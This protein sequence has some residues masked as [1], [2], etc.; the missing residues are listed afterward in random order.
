M[1]TR[2][3]GI[4][5]HPTSLP[6]PNGIGEIGS[7][8]FRF[9]DWLQRAGMTYWQ[10]MPLGPTGFGDSPYAS[11]S[12][13]AGNPMLISL[14]WLTGDGWLQPHELEPLHELAIDA[15][16][17]G[18]VISA[19][20]G[21]LWTAFERWEAADGADSEEFHAFEHQEE[22][23][24][25]DFCLFVAIKES[26]GGAP[27]SD[28][29]PGLRLREPAALDEARTRLRREVLFHAF[30]Q[31][32]FRR[33]WRQLKAYAN[34]RGIRIIGDIPIFV[35]FDSADVWTNR[36]LFELD[37]DGRS[38]VISGVPPDYFS[39][40]GQLW[41][42]PVFDW[43]KNRETGFAWWVERAR[44][45]LD[46]VDIIR[47]DHFRGFAA[48]W[49]VPAGSETAAG[50]YWTRGPGED[51]FDAIRSALGPIEIIVED[52]G[53]ITPDVTSL[54]DRLGY[55]GMKVLQ[56]AFDGDPW[57]MYLP[58]TYESNC[59]VYSGTHDNDTTIGW[60]ETLDDQTR[61]QVQAYIG[62]D[63]ADIA[64]D[65]MRLAFSS[66]ADL[67]IVPLQDVLRLGTGARM[68]RPG[69]P[70]GNWSWRFRQE[71]LND[72]LA[73]GIR[74]FAAMYARLPRPPK[75]AGSDPFDYTAPNSE[76]PL[77]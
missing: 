32:Q 36:D 65:I 14:D 19:K 43:Q 46:L 18:A 67:A 45:T 26:H 8:A 13:F 30:M 38:T 51:V 57:N 21:V 23:W 17:F 28:W 29:E 50:G 39:A 75:P 71:A 33:Q 10:L 16:D 42:N 2:G 49:S 53:L 77:H 70:V 35:A 15:V 25:D 68:N 59:V 62:R 63:G 6:G 55:P 7:L 11:S 1:L 22:A 44:G 61:Q 69:Q 58:H 60:F 20:R 72:A 74:Q 64:W 4:L 31:F 48:S 54:R 41:G 66:V 37:E 56:F 12:A 9:I 73:D 47:I 5:L 24:L 40:D 27:W 3:S 34:D 76:H 52:L